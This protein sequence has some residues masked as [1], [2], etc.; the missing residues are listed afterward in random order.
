MDS[1]GHVEVPPKVRFSV[2]G[3]DL[4]DGAPNVCGLRTLEAEA[5]RGNGD[6]ALK[7]SARG[8]SLTLG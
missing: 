6:L 8:Q 3:Y 7:Y 1:R 4:L 5:T 2:E